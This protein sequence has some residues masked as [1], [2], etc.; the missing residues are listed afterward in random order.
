MNHE[1]LLQT[2]RAD[3]GLRLT[4]Y[5]DTEGVATLG[6]G[7]NVQANGIR[8]DEAE[9]MLMN[10]TAEAIRHARAYPW[11]ARLTD[12]RQEVVVSMLFQLGPQ[13]FAQFK[14][15]I[16]ALS[17]GDYERAAKQMLASKVAREQAPAR[18]QRHAA[19]MRT[20]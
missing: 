17:A 6:Y 3:E 18:W 8:K 5:D 7:R 19:R 20:G 1:R 13:R 2:L 11:F 16:R 10:D 12:A 9:L 14:A 4:L 15:T